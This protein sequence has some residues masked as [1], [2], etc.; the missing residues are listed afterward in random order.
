GPQGRASQGR[1][2][3]AAARG[4][5]S[6]P[7]RPPPWDPAAGTPLAQASC[8]CPGSCPGKLGLGARGAG[9]KWKKVTLSR[10]QVA[11]LLGGVAVLTF[12]RFVVAILLGASLSAP[13]SAPA[14]AQI[15]VCEVL[16]GLTPDVWQGLGVTPGADDQWDNNANWSLGIAP[17]HL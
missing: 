1:R 9:Y 12:V 5:P 2:E 15:N 11:A 17:V 3:R 6:S 10:C 8:P 7:P 14:A 13:G 16:S 4:G